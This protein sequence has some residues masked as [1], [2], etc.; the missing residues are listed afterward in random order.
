[1]S[2]TGRGRGVHVE[3]VAACLGGRV[4]LV[5]LG[6]GLADGGKATQR[7]RQEHGDTGQQDRGDQRDGVQPAGE[8]CAGGGQQGCGEVVG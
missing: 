3:M 5:V 7:G 4:G 8:R 1:M 6:L 2:P